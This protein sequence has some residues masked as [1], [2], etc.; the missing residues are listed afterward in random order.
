MAKEAAEQRHRAAEAEVDEFGVDDWGESEMRDGED[1]YDDQDDMGY[2][3]NC[4]TVPVAILYC[5]AADSNGL[6][7]FR[8][9]DEDGEDDREGDERE[10]DED[11][12][13]GDGMDGS[14]EG[15]EVRMRPSTA[16][17]QGLASRP[18]S[19]KAAGRP[20]SAVPVASS[21]PS[22]PSSIYLTPIRES[23]RRAG[24]SDSEALSPEFLTQQGLSSAHDPIDHTTDLAGPMTADDLEETRAT[25]HHHQHHH[26]P[27]QQQQQVGAGQANLSRPVSAVRFADQHG[28][29]PP[30]S[31]PMSAAVSVGSSEASALPTRVGTPSAQEVRARE[32]EHAGVKGSR[33]RRPGSAAPSRSGKVNFEQHYQGMGGSGSVYLDLE[34]SRGQEHRGLPLAQQA[35]R[36]KVGAAPLCD[37]DPEEISDHDRG[38][39]R[40]SS[41]PDSR[42]GEIPSADAQMLTNHVPSHPRSTRVIFAPPKL[43]SWQDRGVLGRFTESKLIRRSWPRRYSRRGWGFGRWRRSTE[44]GKGSCTQTLPSC[45]AS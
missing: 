14:R 13:M 2:A 34:A 7:S 17:N 22:T 40:A 33:S 4:C 12:Y 30:L 8:L 20:H 23:P 21:R 25:H 35:T 26:R 38:D 16:V 3:T 36:R 18:L 1:Q 6:A 37:R 44:G 39:S 24:V 31:R 9:Y 32:L 15:Q 10:G 28:E 41:R 42:P 27:Q 5:L 43:I 19:A 45:R 11:V 29:V